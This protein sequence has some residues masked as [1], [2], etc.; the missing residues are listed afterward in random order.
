MKPKSICIFIYSSG[1]VL[2]L[3][4]VAKLVSISGENHRIFSNLDPI[5]HISFRHL[6][7]LAAGFE[8]AMSAVCFCDFNLR[9]KAGLMAILATNFV[10][11]RVGL[12]WQ[13]YYGICPCWGNFTEVLHIQARTADTVTKLILAYLLIGSYATLFWLWRQGKKA[14]KIPVLE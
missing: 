11:Y 1:I 9:L 14:N 5:F 8:F 13:G 2:L 12:Y 6:L 10:L 4:A 3:T 7:F